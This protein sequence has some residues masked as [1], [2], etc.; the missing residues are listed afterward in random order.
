[1]I[2][3]ELESWSPDAKD[4]RFD[5]FRYFTA[6][7]GRGVFIKRTAIVDVIPLEN[8]PDIKNAMN[9]PIGNQPPHNLHLDHHSLHKE[10]KKENIDD[11]ENKIDKNKRDNNNNNNINKQY[12]IGDRVMIEGGNK[13]YIRYIGK[14]IKNEGVYGIELDLAIPKGTDGRRNN[15]RYF[16]CRNNHAIF[17]RKHTILEIID[18]D[19]I[20]IPSKGNRVKLTKGRF[21]IIQQIDEQDDGSLEYQICIDQL[22]DR[23]LITKND[24]SHRRQ[25]S[26]SSSTSTHLRR[27]SINKNEIKSGRQS[28]LLDIEDSAYK[29]LMGNTIDEDSDNYDSDDDNYTALGETIELRSGKIGTIRFIGPVHFAKGNWIGV[30]LHDHFGPHDGA[31]RGVR[32]FTCPQKRGIFVK[33]IKGRK[34]DD[35]TRQHL[36]RR[37]PECFGEFIKKRDPRLA[38]KGVG[39]VCDGCSK[40]GND[41]SSD[42]WYFQCGQCEQTDFCLKCM[43]KL[44]AVSSD[45]MLDSYQNIRAK[46]K[47]IGTEWIFEDIHNDQDDDDDDQDDNND[48]NNNDNDNK[49]SEINENNNKN[50]NDQSDEEKGPSKFLHAPIKSIFDHFNKNN[51]GKL[52][53][54]DI[55]DL[56][57]ASKHELDKTPFLDK[58]PMRYQ[59]FEQCWKDVLPSAAQNILEYISNHMKNQVFI[60]FFL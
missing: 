9:L 3:V 19:E 12:Q 24:I 59:Q 42:D 28:G 54:N 21:G 32:Y 41:F 56:Y 4:G 44:P 8:D 27:L 45:D 34:K 10:D 49:N 40:H 48:N 33:Q 57:K 30:E 15:K 58:T 46:F 13:G 11:D 37:C 51:D 53:D 38:Y 20:V 1:M 50:D 16:V 29:K 60:L 35:P 22:I 36:K 25:H 14:D 31:V 23:T 2:G 47:P 5:G 52:T 43:L 7:D 39:I 18:E 26:F 55:N 6:P 17:V